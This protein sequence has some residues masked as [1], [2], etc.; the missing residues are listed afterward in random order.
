[1]HAKISG[2]EIPNQIHF[3]ADRKSDDKGRRYS[4]HCAENRQGQNTADTGKE[5]G[6]GHMRRKYAVHSKTNQQ[7]AKHNGDTNHAGNLDRLTCCEA[8]VEQNGYKM[9][10]QPAKP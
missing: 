10:H 7:T 1:M 6:N 3:G 8:D 2:D 4:D 5:N 9:N